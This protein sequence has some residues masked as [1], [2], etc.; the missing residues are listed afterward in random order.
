MSTAHRNNEQAG[1]LIHSLRRSKIYT[2]VS[3]SIDCPYFQLT[4]VVTSQDLLGQ[5]SNA[6]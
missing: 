4:I 5:D 2:K 3:G 6:N 1:D